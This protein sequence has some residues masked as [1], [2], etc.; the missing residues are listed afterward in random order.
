[1][2]KYEPYVDCALARF[3]L[4]RALQNKRI[5]HYLFWYLKSE[6]TDPAVTLRFALLLEAY[7]RGVGTSIDWLIKQHDVMTL[8][9][10]IS[11]ELKAA[12]SPA[13]RKLLL[14]RNF[15]NLK[16]PDTFGLPIEPTLIAKGLVKSK[17]KF[18]DSKKLPLWLVFENA[19]PIGNDIY[20]MFKSGDD[21]RQD[22]L[23]LQL[24]RIMERLWQAKS[25]DLCMSPY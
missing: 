3:L 21:L 25:L 24:I 22:M 4:T 5:G 12:K 18:M 2:L 16:L 15:D 20:L 19:D 13:E 23:T 11:N 8:F 14:Q 6:M 17:C 9:L 7:L 1:M 10:N